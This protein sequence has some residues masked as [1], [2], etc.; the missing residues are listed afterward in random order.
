LCAVLAARSARTVLCPLRVAGFSVRRGACALGSVQFVSCS[1]V[2]ATRHP[3]PLS[4]VE[5]LRAHQLPVS[6]SIHLNR[7]SPVVPACRCAAALVWILPKSLPWLYGVWPAPIRVRS[8]RHHS[9]VV[10]DSFACVSNSCVES[11]SCSPVR[12]LGSLGL[13]SHRVIDSAGQRRSS[14]CRVC[15]SIYVTLLCRRRSMRHQEIPRIE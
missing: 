5:S 14:S 9:V 3:W 7:S 1:A 4:V 10:G 13:N 6:R 11:F 15:S 2:R 8:Y 12:P